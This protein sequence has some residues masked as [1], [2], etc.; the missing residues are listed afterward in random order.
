MGFHVYFGVRAFWYLDTLILFWC[1]VQRDLSREFLHRD[2]IL[3]LMLLLLTISL[4]R[5]GQLQMPLRHQVN[6]LEVLLPR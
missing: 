3:P 1:F 5:T 6:M 2:T 4:Q